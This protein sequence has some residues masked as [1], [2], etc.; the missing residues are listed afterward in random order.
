MKRTTLS[1]MKAPGRSELNQCCDF[2][3]HGSSPLLVDRGPLSLDLWVF[4]FGSSVLG[5]SSLGPSFFGLCLKGRKSHPT[6]NGWMLQVLSTNKQ[7]LLVSNPT[8][9][10]G[11]LFKSFLQK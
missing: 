8:K 11:R 3:F 5:L 10:V 2:F 1:T 9:A 6:G 7:S 4:G